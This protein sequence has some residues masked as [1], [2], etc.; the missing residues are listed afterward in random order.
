MGTRYIM[1]LIKKRDIIIG[2][3]KEKNFKIN[4]LGILLWTINIYT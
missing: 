2:T 3:N 1:K 4:K